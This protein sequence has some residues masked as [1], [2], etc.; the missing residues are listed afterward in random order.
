[1]K[2][3]LNDHDYL[4]MQARESFFRGN[5]R[6]TKPE[7]EE[8]FRIWYRL[9]G[10]EYGSSRCGRC[11]AGVRSKLWKVYLEQRDNPDIITTENYE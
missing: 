9:T 7:T 6:L 5:N 10:Q 4:W 1:M 8:L 11:V 2:V 3:R